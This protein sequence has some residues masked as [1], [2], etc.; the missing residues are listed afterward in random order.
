MAG[1]I[2]V[3]DRI[4]YRNT[5]EKRNAVDGELLLSNEN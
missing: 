1:T 3:R 4:A 2:C 5:S